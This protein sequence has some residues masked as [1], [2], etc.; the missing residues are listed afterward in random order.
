VS[1]HRRVLILGGARSGKSRYAQGLA[2]ACNLEMVF[3]ATAQGHDDE[4]RARI[5]A[6]R[7]QRGRGWR[8]VEE[9]SALTAALCTEARPET[10]VLVDCVTL[11]LSNLLL[12]GADVDEA[13]TDLVAALT[14]IAG[15]VI[16]VSNEVGS[17]VVPATPLGR[18]FRDAQGRLNQAI[19]TV[20]DAV[21]LV[22][23]G[24]PRL[25][26]PVPEFTLSL[27]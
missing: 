21:I 6:H 24:C 26:K 1:L 16:L 8:T 22:T 9:P 12:A 4:M 2:E 10:V 20:C 7:A 5:A 15:P 13:A 19:A 23:A 11:W 14:R 17:G 27:G 3:V 18:A 25:L